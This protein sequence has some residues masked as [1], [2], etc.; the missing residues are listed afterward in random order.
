MSTSRVASVSFAAPKRR[1][2]ARTASS[3]IFIA[4]TAAAAL[5]LGCAWTVYANV[6]AAS[7]Y[8]QLDSAS[9][10]AHV[11]APAASF[12]ARIAPV[13]SQTARVGSPPLISAPAAVPAEPSLSF[14]DRFA[15]ASAQDVAPAPQ[16]ETP[17]LAEA[18]T[19]QVETARQAEASKAKGSSRVRLA[20][21]GGSSAEHEINAK[22]TYHDA[23]AANDY[24]SDQLFGLETEPVTDGPL[25][26]KWRRVEAIITKDLELIVQCQAAKPC[27]APAQKLIDLSRQGT[28]RSGRARI[29]V[30]NRAVNLAI[31]PV[32]D[33]TQWGIP[34][35]WSEPLETLH[36]NSGDCEDYAI[37]KYAAL[38]AAGLPKDAVKIVVLRNRLPNEDHAV[39]AVQVDHQWLILDNRTLTL[40]RD[41][42][43]MRAI[44]EFVLGDQGVRRFV[45]SSLNRRVA[46]S[47]PSS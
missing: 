44:P 31:R 46:A 6:F 20:A 39:V 26:E 4:G 18:P 28:G 9:F 1:T 3:Q 7:P 8:P 41:T 24:Q 15:A 30:I 27:P 43:V 13:A 22:T 25:L 10:D 12:A 16:P 23:S 11:T 36:S 35:R 29:G 5:V 34:D 19:A 45:W 42:D 32:S 38:L 17:R 33:E 2:P 14:S 37:V 21:V 40:V 47:A